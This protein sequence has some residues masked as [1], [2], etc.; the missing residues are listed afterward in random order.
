MFDN[1]N[2]KLNDCIDPKCTAL[3]FPHCSHG[4]LVINI[5]LVFFDRYGGSKDVLVIL[6]KQDLP[7]FGLNMRLK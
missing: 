7:H 2:P 1:V 3:F 5:V 4:I 6:L